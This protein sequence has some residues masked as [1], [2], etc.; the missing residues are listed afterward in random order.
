MKKNDSRPRLTLKLKKE[1]L[2]A[3]SHESLTAVHGAAVTSVQGNGCDIGS[4][5]QHICL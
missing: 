1:S 2:R 5:V 4:R 3:L